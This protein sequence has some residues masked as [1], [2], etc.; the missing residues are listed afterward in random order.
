MSTSFPRHVFST[1]HPKELTKDRKRCFE[2]DIWVDDPDLPN[3]KN[4]R[5][6]HAAFQ[7]KERRPAVC[8]FEAYRQQIDGKYWFPVYTYADDTLNLGYGC[9]GASKVVV[10]YDHYKKFQFK[11]DTEHT[12]TAKEDTD[13]AGQ[14]LPA[15]PANLRDWQDHYEEGLWQPS[16]LVLSLAFFAVADE[17]AQL[18]LPQHVRKFVAK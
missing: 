17:V 14:L 3:R 18:K 12:R 6:G 10:K 5:Q 1:S 13:G 8:E 11:T 16:S 2:G 15:P 4:L 7:E 9:A